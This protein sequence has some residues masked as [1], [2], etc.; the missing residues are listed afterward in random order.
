MTTVEFHQKLFSFLMRGTDTLY[1]KKW[2]I[3]RNKELVAAFLFTLNI[4]NSVVCMILWAFIYM[5]KNGLF[6]GK[7][8][9]INV[10]LL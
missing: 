8:W 6:I 10:F 3:D 9:L 7:M 2:R 4:R 1:F 5:S